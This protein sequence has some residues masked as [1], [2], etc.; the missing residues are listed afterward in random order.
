MSEMPTNENSSFSPHISSS[1]KTNML[2]RILYHT[3][4]LFQLETAPIMCSDKRK[5][6]LQKGR[7]PLLSIVVGFTG[8][9]ESCLPKGSTYA[10]YNCAYLVLVFL[11]NSWYNYSYCIMNT[12]HI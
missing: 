11:S 12:Y 9:D 2:I 6:T 3:R 5:T 10:Y 8:R 4:I 7:F 1:E